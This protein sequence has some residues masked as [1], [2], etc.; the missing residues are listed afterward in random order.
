MRQLI[1]DAPRKRFELIDSPANSCKS[2]RQRT[3]THCKLRAHYSQTLLIRQAQRCVLFFSGGFKALIRGV[4]FPFAPDW[5]G[6]LHIGLWRVT[7]GRVLRRRSII[8]GWP[9][10]HSHALRGNAA[11]DAL[12]PKSRRRASV[13]AFPRGAWE[14]SCIPFGSG[15]AREGVG[16]NHHKTHRQKKPRPAYTERGFVLFRPAT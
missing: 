15:L 13:E 14:R 9:A 3:D 16:K 2:E 6:R 11:R 1:T 5:R 4:A 12:R 10:D 8:I 7:E